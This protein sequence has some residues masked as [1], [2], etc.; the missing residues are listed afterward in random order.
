MVLYSVDERIFISS[1]SNFPQGL[2][3]DLAESENA[4]LFG[5]G[6]TCNGFRLKVM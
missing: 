3:R 4:A 5:S 1:S 2:G 6:R